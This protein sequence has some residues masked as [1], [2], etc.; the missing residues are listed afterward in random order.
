MQFE[1]NVSHRNCVAHTS[2]N[3]KRGAES[4]H[5][6]L[7]WRWMAQAVQVVATGAGHA[8]EG[9]ERRKERAMRGARQLGG[10]ASRAGSERLSSLSPGLAARMESWRGR[11]LQLTASWASAQEARSPCPSCHPSFSG[12][13]GKCSIYKPLTSRDLAATVW[14]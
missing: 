2:H 4:Q 14:L 7:A 11:C 13:K 1:L 8:T 9:G 10:S 12:L 3:E 6:G 5:L